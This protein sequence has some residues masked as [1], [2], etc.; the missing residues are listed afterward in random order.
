MY[1]PGILSGY[2]NGVV[3]EDFLKCSNPRWNVNHGVNI[4]GYG[5]VND[6]DRVR[7]WCKEYW[8]IRNSWGANWGEEGFFRL[9]MDDAGSNDKPY[10]SCLVNL[11]ATYPTME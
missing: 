1:A 11:F 6:N 7:G 8:V 5:I 10:G 3:T 9:C 4:V 2:K